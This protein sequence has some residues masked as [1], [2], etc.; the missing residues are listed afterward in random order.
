MSILSLAPLTVLPAS[1]LAQIEA[2]HVAGFD[3]VGLRLQPVIPTDIDVMR[4]ANL[5]RDIAWRLAATG[6]K[7]LDI[8]VFRIGPHAD[9]ASMLPAMEF[10]G[11]LGAQ[12]MLCTS[13]L[14]DEHVASEE[15]R[16]VEKFAELC[17]AGVRL[18]IK[19]MLEFMIYRSV[20]TIEDALRMVKLVNHPNLGICV[21]A[22]HLS[23][24]GGA[25]DSLRKVDPRLLCYAQICDAP[26]ALPPASRIPLEARSHRLYPGEGSLPLR[27]LLD[28]LPPDI[29]LSVEAPNSQCAH[30]SAIERAHAVA[31]CT[32]ALLQSS[33]LRD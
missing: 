13:M 27:E 7:V 23:R 33:G 28:A 32:R 1:P 15:S 24:S 4:D 12:Y 17:D 31:R 29:P 26:A 22:L 5:L 3:A 16:T 10:A 18:G 30:L 19:P 20:G 8:E 14:V 21:D 2:A 11:S 25:P 9:I 6:L